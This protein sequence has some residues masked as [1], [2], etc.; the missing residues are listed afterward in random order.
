MNQQQVS[1]LRSRINAAH[2]AGDLKLAAALQSRLHAHFTAKADGF[3]RSAE[4][5]RWMD[6]LMERA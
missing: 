1:A 2:D 6:R 5:S 3:M 4:G